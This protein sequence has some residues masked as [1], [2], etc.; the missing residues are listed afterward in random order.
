MKFNPLVPELSVSNLPRSRA[1]Y[2][3]TLGFKVEYERPANKFIY[4]SLQGA[5][6]MIE[7]TNGHWS[8]GELEH[9]YGRGIN[10]QFA[11]DNVNALIESLRENDVPL[12]RPLTESWYRGGDTLYGQTEFLIQDPDGYLLRFAQDIGSKPAK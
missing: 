12:F 1:F 10:F 6:I 11:V 8:T 2:V 5:Q 9:P 7:E 4:L 3:D